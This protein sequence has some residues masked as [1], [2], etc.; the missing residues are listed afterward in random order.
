M[1]KLQKAMK[2]TKPVINMSKEEFQY[3]QKP[4]GKA[5]YVHHKKVGRPRVDPNKK[6][7]PKDKIKCDVCG[8]IYIRSG[9]YCHKNTIYHKERL[10]INKKLAKL[11]IED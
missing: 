3:S 5:L 1:E 10:K 7:S 2:E 11:L 4:M 9:S 8:K 6:T